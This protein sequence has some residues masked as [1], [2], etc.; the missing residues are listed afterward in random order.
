MPVSRFGFCISFAI[1][2]LISS[3]RR[4]SVNG[5]D[6]TFLSELDKKG[7]ESSKDRNEFIEKHKSKS[8]MLGEQKRPPSKY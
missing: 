2:I 5:Q 8:G 3:Q 7:T 1:F 4:C 6:D